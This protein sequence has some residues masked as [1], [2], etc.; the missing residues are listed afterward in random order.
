MRIFP[1]PVQPEPP[2]WI[3]AAGSPDTFA[4]AGRIGANILTNLLGHEATTI[5]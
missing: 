2:I 4:M 5:W 1:P 3:T